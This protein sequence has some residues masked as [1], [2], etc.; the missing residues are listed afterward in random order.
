ME[1]H[2]DVGLQQTHRV[3]GGSNDMAMKLQRNPSNPDTNGQ[4]RVSIIPVKLHA[5]TVISRE[6]SSLERV[7]PLYIAG[8]YMR[9]RRL[10]VSDFHHV[11]TAPDLLHVSS[12]LEMVQHLP[13]G[14]GGGGGRHNYTGDPLSK[15]RK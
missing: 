9:R 14:G 3:H 4:E 15:E 8:V 10:T 2:L 7:A 6:V 5:I 11:P 12:P 1:S 13:G